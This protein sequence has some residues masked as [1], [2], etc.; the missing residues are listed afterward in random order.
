M[1]SINSQVLLV[2]AAVA[3][4]VTVF[5]PTPSE[6]VLS[7]TGGVFKSPEAQ[8]YFARRWGGAPVRL[9]LFFM[10]RLDQIYFHSL[11]L[12]YSDQLVFWHVHGLNSLWKV[13]PFVLTTQLLSHFLWSLDAWKS[14]NCTTIPMM[15]EKRKWNDERDRDPTSSELC[16]KKE[17]STD[18]QNW[19][20]KK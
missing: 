3:A 9:F 13:E 14:K 1:Q 7:G 2:V 15:D 17:M 5:C 12:D 20:T 8:E 10:K 11:M 4:F 16:F 18:L 6:A 19:P